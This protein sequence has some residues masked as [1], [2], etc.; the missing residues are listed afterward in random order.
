MHEWQQT[1]MASRR[2]GQGA[3]GCIGGRRPLAKYR[4]IAS[5]ATDTLQCVTRR[6]D[7][8]GLML[9]VGIERSK[10]DVTKAS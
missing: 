8:G 4:L 1:A 6:T 10:I 9:S 5:K 2:D 7:S 3:I